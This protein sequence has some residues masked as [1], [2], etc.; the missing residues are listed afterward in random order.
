MHLAPDAVA[1]GQR[2]GAIAFGVGPHRVRRSSCFGLRGPVLVLTAAGAAEHGGRDREQ[3]LDD[4]RRAGCR[5]PARS[6]SATPLRSRRSP[7]WVPAPTSVAAAIT[8]TAG[9]AMPTGASPPTA[10]PAPAST[11]SASQRDTPRRADPRAGQPRAPR[12]GRHD[13][14]RDRHPGRPVGVV[15]ARRRPQQ[16]GQPGHLGDAHCAAPSRCERAPRSRCTGPIAVMLPPAP[17]SRA[18]Q[19]VTNRRSRPPRSMTAPVRRVFM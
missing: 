8:A 11:A 12:H 7:P 10:P 18:G 2:G 4:D 9:N 17:G 1:L 3:A 19:A 14:Q 5:R 15:L 6:S 13:Q 16:R